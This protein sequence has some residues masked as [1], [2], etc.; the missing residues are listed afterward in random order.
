MAQ[1]TGNLIKTIIWQSNQNHYRE[2]QDDDVRRND[3]ES[4]KS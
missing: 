4:K 1:P 3:I 2:N